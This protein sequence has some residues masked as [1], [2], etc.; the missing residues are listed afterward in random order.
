MES[1]NRSCD[2][3]I[4][5]FTLEEADLPNQPPREPDWR[6]QGIVTSPELITNIHARK[7]LFMVGH[8]NNFGIDNHYW[9]CLVRYATG[10]NPFH[11]VSELTT[12]S[13]LRGMITNNV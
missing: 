6:V 10:I 5:S 12:A 9:R 7:S 2:I 4:F 13:I 1:L 3:V 11:F 8:L